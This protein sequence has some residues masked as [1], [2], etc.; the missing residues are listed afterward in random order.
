MSS[1]SGEK[2]HII[3]GKIK[4]DR[5]STSI[6]PDKDVMF[7]VIDKKCHH[8]VMIVSDINENNAHSHTVFVCDVAYKKQDFDEF[9]KSLRIDKSRVKPV[10]QIKYT[11]TKRTS[12]T[13]P[14]KK[15]VTKVMEFTY[16]ISRLDC[17]KDSDVD[18]NVTNGLYVLVHN[19][20]IVIDE[21]K[22]TLVH[23]RELDALID[24]IGYKGKVYGVKKAAYEKVKSN[25]GWENFL[26]KA[27]KDAYNLMS[28]VDIGS[29]RIAI[30]TLDNISYHTNGTVATF[31]QNIS[32]GNYKVKPADIKNAVDTFNQLRSLIKTD[33]SIFDKLNTTF[34]GNSIISKSAVTTSIKSNTYYSQLDSLLNKYPLFNYF[35]SYSLT[36]GLMKELVEYVNLKG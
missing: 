8:N 21:V 12:S 28:G 3:S 23:P 24:F 34:F 4:S 6:R 5:Y 10:S 35:R 17:W 26:D 22:N 20:Y 1:N 19:S 30:E 14:S 25:A 18:I 7:Y 27:K 29:V 32:T 9:C 11:P 31:I 15:H 36:D 16:D 13:G 2:K 33:L